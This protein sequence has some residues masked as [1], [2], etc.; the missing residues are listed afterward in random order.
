[1]A[2][3][4]GKRARV[5]R[6][7]TRAVSNAE[8]LHAG[9]VANAVL[10][11][12]SDEAAYIK[13]GD[14]YGRRRRDCLYGEHKARRRR[15]KR[16]VTL[17]TRRTPASAFMEPVSRGNDRERQ[18]TWREHNPGHARP[19]AV[20][21]FR[22]IP[23]VCGFRARGDAGLPVIPSPDFDGQLPADLQV[24]RMTQR[25]LRRQQEHCEGTSRLPWLTAS[26]ATPS[27]PCHPGA[28]ASSA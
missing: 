27:A 19:R 1:V 11:L 22:Q 21:P 6:S 25:A 20:T 18:G 14:T 2:S 13:R 26:A 10:F 28:T 4:Y 8:T 24:I 23:S 5:H 3:Q 7:V 16:N 17:K 12:A 15:Q 9:D